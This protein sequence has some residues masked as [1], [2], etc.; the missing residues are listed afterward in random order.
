MKEVR[1]LT[2]LIRIPLGSAWQKLSVN[3]PGTHVGSVPMLLADGVDECRKAVRINLRRG[4]R[5]IKVMTS[6]GVTSRD[7]NPM[8]QQFSDEELNHIVDEAGRMNMV[9]AAHAIGKAGIMAA[10]RAG[11]HVIEHGSFADE[12]TLNAM[13][14][15]GVM[16]VATITPIQ[17]I[18]DNEDAYPPEMYR[19]TVKFAKVHKQMYRNAI[20][21]GVKCALGSDLF[22]GTGTVLGAGLN[23]HEVVYAVEAGMSPL[24]AI[25]AATAHGPETLGPQAPKSGIIQEGYDADFLGLEENPLDDIE[26]LQSPKKIKYIWKG[27][28][29]MKAPGLDPWDALDA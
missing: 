3:A 23:G 18:L 25:T 16:L 26:V 4:A 2:L 28:K 15:N 14:R 17:S 29:L 22:G 21:A 1:A 8:L 5:V 11:F 27:G 19:E 6:G 24:E 20:K 9:C 10:I 7:D 13:N 12:E